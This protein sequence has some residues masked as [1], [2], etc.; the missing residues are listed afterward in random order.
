MDHRWAYSLL[1]VDN[2][3]PDGYKHTVNHETGHVLG[4]ADPFVSNSCRPACGTVDIFGTTC[5]TLNELGQ[6]VWVESVMH[7]NYYCGGE[8]V[9]AGP[10]PS[11]LDWPTVRDQYIVDTIENFTD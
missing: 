6:V 2:I 5:L 10:A 1:D 11:S 3:G 4:L 7:S 8:V 9:Q